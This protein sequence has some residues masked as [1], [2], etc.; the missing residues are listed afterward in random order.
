VRKE[1]ILAILWL[2]WR[3]TKN[4]F[5]RAGKINAVISVFMLVVLVMA[6]GGAVVGGF[7]VGLLG[8]SQTRP[9]GLLL[10]WDAVM[11]VFLIFWLSGLLVEI[12]RSESID[13]SRLLHLPVTLD[14]VFLFNYLASLLT[15][16]ILIFV[17][18]MLAV[19]LGL[20]LS[21]GPWMVLMIPLLVGFILL[22][23]AW[24]YCLRG[25]LAALMSNQRRKRSI[26]VWITL[27]FILVAQLPNAFLHSPM[28]RKNKSGTAVKGAMENSERVVAGHLL[29][30]PGWV[31]YGAM[32]LANKNS[33]PALGAIAVCCLL[34]GYGL[35]RAYRTTLKVYTGVEAPVKPT[36]EAKVDKSRLLLVERRVPGLPE[37]TA[38]LALATFRSLLRAPEL[39]MALVMPVVAGVFAASAFLTRPKGPITAQLAPFVTGCFA[40]FAVFCFSNLMANMFGLDRSGFRALVLLP[41]RRQHILL[42]KNLA[43]LPFIAGSGVTFLLILSW[44]LRLSWHNTLTGFFQLIIAFLVF[45][46][47]CN[48]LSI[49]APYRFSPGTLQ[50]KK[51]KAI[52]FVAVLATM[53]SA[54][55]ALIPVLI[56]PSVQLLFN[57]LGWVSWLP[58]N[59]LVATLIAGLVV[60]LYWILLPMQGR[61]L[62]KRE[63][64]I[65][66]SVTEALE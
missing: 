34:G 6:A 31:G 47:M 3:L 22:L 15:P 16:S 10:F 2:R 39:K 55:L 28:F 35:K 32:G 50:T 40:V 58:V 24:T 1:H 26:I 29:I 21:R 19:C 45:S 65:L 17:P 56:P 5:A 37:D 38:A 36:R 64:N 54:P 8:L 30:P 12:Q 52:V 44:F 63:R 62:Q 18:G 66:A 51:P 33:W 14:Q 49:L 43:V 42:A 25:W 9:M 20:M 11:F 41:T 59:V 46:L 48:L 57:M 53:V 61:L 23:T 7:L 60:W 27:G 13:L 4:Q